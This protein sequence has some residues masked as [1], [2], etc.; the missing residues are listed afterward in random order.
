MLNKI[1]RTLNPLSF[2]GTAAAIHQQPLYGDTDSFIFHRS[3]LPRIQSMFGKNPGQISDDLAD[4]PC[5]D[6]TKGALVKIVDYAAGCPKW[7]GLRAVRP[8]GTVKDVIKM[9][10]INNTQARF[11]MPDGSEQQGL[12]FEDFVSICEHAHNLPQ[13]YPTFNNNTFS[14]VRVLM[15]DR[16]LRCGVKVRPGCVKGDRQAFDLFRGDVLRTMFAQ[17]GW[18]GRVKYD[19]GNPNSKTVWTVPQNWNLSS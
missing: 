8:D 18:T 13:T 16:L 6:F 4:R 12:S 15:E 2:S 11:V 9:A 19:T 5:C 10:S 3:Q 7:Y 14:K 17:G 1:L